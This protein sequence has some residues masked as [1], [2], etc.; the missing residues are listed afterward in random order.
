MRRIW[1]LVAVVAACGKKQTAPSAQGS[2]SA[3]ASG[4]GGGSAVAMAA[5]GAGS[6]LVFDEPDGS[7]DDG[8]DA[9]RFIFTGKVPRLPAVSPDGMLYAEIDSPITGMPEPPMP[10]DLVLYKVNSDTE[11]ERIHLFDYDEGSGARDA[12]ENGSAGSAWVGPQLAKTL[13]TRGTAAVKRLAGFHSLT[14]ASVNWGDDDKKPISFGAATL[15][16]DE[17]LDGIAVEL[18][19][20]SGRVLHRAEVAGYSSGSDDTT[21]CGYTPTLWAAG[22]DGPMLF[23]TVGY[24]YRDDCDPPKHTILGWSLD[25]AKASDEDAGA[26]TVAHQLE[27]PA[28]AGVVTSRGVTEHDMLEDIA[29]TMSRDGKSAWATGASNDVRASDVLVKTPAGWQ[30]AGAAWTRSYDNDKANA[31]AKAGKLKPRTLEGG[32]GD[33]SLA[34]AFKKMTTDG[35]D[36]AAAKRADLVAIGSAFGERTV[37]GAGFARAWNA[38]WKGKTT[39]DSLVAKTTPSGT[40]GWVTAS[41]RLQKAGYAIP[42]LIFAVFDKTDAG[43]SLVHIHFAV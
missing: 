21:R 12:M 7:D 40:T 36:A 27:Q 14:M 31:D 11:A 17:G 38:A 35:L 23:V 25:P 15:T 43:W 20:A 33:A 13:A 34:D 28:P 10:Y 26:G 29:F 4:N 30:I 22:T 24:R 41:V 19:D 2:G 8:P 5:P 9:M 6:G 3:L 1:V 18:R 32:P 39:I 37:G 16:A 42:F